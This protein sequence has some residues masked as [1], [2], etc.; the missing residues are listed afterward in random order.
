MLVHLESDLAVEVGAC[1]VHGFLVALHGAAVG[2]SFDNGGG[3][4][5]G[6]FGD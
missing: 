4:V 5:G 2:V 6:G 1:G 3:S